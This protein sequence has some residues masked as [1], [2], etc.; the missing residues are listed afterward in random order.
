MTYSNLTDPFHSL[1]FSGRYLRATQ[2]IKTN[3]V[4][5]K[6]KVQTVL[7]LLLYRGLHWTAAFWGTPLSGRLLEHSKLRVWL[8]LHRPHQT[9]PPRSWW[10]GGYGTTLVSFLPWQVFPGGAAS[11]TP[12]FSVRLYCLQSRTTQTPHRYHFWNVYNAI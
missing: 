12:P 1:T 6:G 2:F 10:W 4:S 8:D 11:R 7:S 9:M 3:T 5:R